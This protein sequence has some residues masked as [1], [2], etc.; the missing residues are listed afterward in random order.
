MSH[1]ATLKFNIPGIIP[2]WIAYTLSSRGRSTDM[3]NL[4]GLPSTFLAWDNKDNKDH[5]GN[6]KALKISNL[7]R[8]F[9]IS[10]ILAD[11][12]IMQGA[13]WATTKKGSSIDDIPCPE[14]CKNLKIS[15]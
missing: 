2:T 7:W 15:F 14:K 3:N 12:C 13:S 5:S 4:F 10:P 8:G 9:E 11:M 1:K 6:T